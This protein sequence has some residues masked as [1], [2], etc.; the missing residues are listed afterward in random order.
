[1]GADGD[2]AA[3][4]RVREG[5]AV[6]D[7]GFEAYRAA[8]EV[9]VIDADDRGPLA[10]L[11]VDLIHEGELRAGA[12]ADELAGEQ[13]LFGARLQADDEVEGGAGAWRGVWVDRSEGVH[14]SGKSEEEC[15]KGLGKE[16]HDLYLGRIGR[17]LGG[18]VH[19]ATA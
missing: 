15:E 6:G 12:E 13:A 16:S 18:D 5:D 10:G 8:V 14:G 2:D 11:G 4:A 9:G 17:T 19:F 1:V 3:G 7:G